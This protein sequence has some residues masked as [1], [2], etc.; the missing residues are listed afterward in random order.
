MPI[1]IRGVLDDDSI[2]EITKLFTHL[3]TK[4]KRSHDFAQ[5]LLKYA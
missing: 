1:H 2:G 5:K 4:L 3:L